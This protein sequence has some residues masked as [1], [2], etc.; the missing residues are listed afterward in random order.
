[1][2]AN[3]EYFKVFYYVARHGSVTKAAGE[4][5]ISQP[6]VSQSLRQLEK[7]LGV[8]LFARAPRGVKGGAASVFL[9]GEGL[10]AD[11]TGSGEGAQDAGAGAG[12]DPHRRQ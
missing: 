4:L 7:S 11:R 5:A 2:I 1:M 3:L 12:G 9:C 10:R 8:T 6:A